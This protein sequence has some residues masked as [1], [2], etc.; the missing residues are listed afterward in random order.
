M[1]LK[2]KYLLYLSLSADDVFFQVADKR[3]PRDRLPLA[4]ETHRAGRQV[5][6]PQEDRPQ[7]RAAQRRF[8]FG[9]A[10]LSGD[11]NE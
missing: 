7:I 6:A 4:P 11:E 9:H 10:P 2:S 5:G 1:R 8:S 3:E